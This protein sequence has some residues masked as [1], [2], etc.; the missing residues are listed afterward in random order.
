V[1]VSRRVIKLVASSTAPIAG[2]EQEPILS[3]GS[4]LT[5]QD[6]AEAHLALTALFERSLARAGS[7]RLEYVVLRF[8]V[9]HG[10]FSSPAEL[11]GFLAGQQELGLT[12]AGVARLLARIEKRGLASGTAL[13]GE[14]PA[15]ATPSGSM[16]ISQL[17]EAMI[18]TTRELF[19]GIDPEDQATAH[20]VLNL[21]TERA[22]KISGLE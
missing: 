9:G 6:I 14:G 17:I 7:D 4:V 3:L 16:M 18:P 21:L 2:R 19:A 11:H 5:G 12:A 20:R 8:L 15:Q 13:P 1:N 22:A 10:P